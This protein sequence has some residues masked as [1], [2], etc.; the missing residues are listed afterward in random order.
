MYY[1]WFIFYFEHRI[2][3][4]YELLTFIDI[5]NNRTCILVIIIFIIAKWINTALNT[6]Q[7]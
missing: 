7:M 3:W 6:M 1:S 2:S 4:L 5:Y